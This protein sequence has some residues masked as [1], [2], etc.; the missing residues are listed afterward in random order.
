M[1]GYFFIWKQQRLAS[2]ANWLAL[3]QT[4][5]QGKCDK[6]QGWNHKSLLLSFQKTHENE[7]LSRPR[8][9]SAAGIESTLKPSFN[10]FLL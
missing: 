7:S 3:L 9:F 1:F 6:M 5:L 10:L 2:T 8:C 4:P